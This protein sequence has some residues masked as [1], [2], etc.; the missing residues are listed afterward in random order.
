MSGDKPPVEFPGLP[1]FLRGQL[2]AS[3]L[4]PGVQGI[5]SYRGILMQQHG[6]SSWK[7]NTALIL[8]DKGK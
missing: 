7:T 8:Q 5:P 4:V 3:S 2:A 6:H 1:L